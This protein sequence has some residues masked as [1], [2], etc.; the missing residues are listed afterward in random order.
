MRII[1]LF[2]QAI[3]LSSILIS[4]EA[5]ADSALLSAPHQMRHAMDHQ[6]GNMVQ[7]SAPQRIQQHAAQLKQNKPAGSERQID[8]K[9][10][11]DCTVAAEQQSQLQKKARL[12]PCEM[13]PMKGDEHAHH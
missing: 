3:I 1:N 9:P 11:L 4:V 7:V 12:P 8:S 13:T 2:A 6:K 5:M 10:R